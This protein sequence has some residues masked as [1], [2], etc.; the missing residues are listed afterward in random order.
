MDTRAAKAFDII[1]NCIPD[2]YFQRAQ[3]M[4]IYTCSN[5]IMEY[6]TN[7]IVNINK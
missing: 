7:G 2:N 4:Y 3:T 5:V 1:F 6:G